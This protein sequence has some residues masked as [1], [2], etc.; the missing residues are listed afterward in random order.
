[1]RFK[2]FSLV[3]FLLIPH[4][5]SSQAA[6][7]SLQSPFVSYLNAEVNGSSV[8]LTWRDPADTEGMV[9]EIHRYSRAITVENL[10][11]TELVAHI[12]PGIR[13]FTDHPDEDTSWWYAIISIKDEKAINLIVPWR[14]A[15][16]IPVTI[17]PKDEIQ[18]N[19]AISAPNEPQRYNPPIRPA[20]LPFL[21]GRGFPDRTLLSAEAARAL[22]N[23][24]S[25]ETGELWVPAEREILKADYTDA[26]DKSQVVLKGILEGSFARGDWPA[27]EAELLELSAIKN[28]PKDLK[29][30][31]LFYKGEC[32][33]FQYNLQGAF[34]SFL[35][36]S[37]YYYKE[38]RRWMIR[39]YRDLTP[40]S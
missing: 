2:S 38:S 7:I 3:L 18:I 19:T 22:G 24:L 40:V 8:V 28:L 26:G 34:L 21:E 16:G 25:P 17:K 9:Y 23:I 35:V 33:Y 15:L 13:A 29:A 1:M 20:P 12:A 10:N 27:A 36:S 31:I 39:I 4:V 32:R 14:N 37:D 11:R 5:L 30:R 6:G